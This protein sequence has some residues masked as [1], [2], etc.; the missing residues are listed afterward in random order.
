MTDQIA[1]TSLIGLVGFLGGCGV[2]TLAV[3]KTVHM[4]AATVKELHEWRE[5]HA[6]DAKNVYHRISVAEAQIA[7]LSA[8]QAS[9]I[10]GMAELKVD[11]REIWDVVGEIR[12]GSR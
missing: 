1:I 5:A 7:S 10:S 12:N 11:V 2:T 9:I 3:Y 6:N 4:T 8:G